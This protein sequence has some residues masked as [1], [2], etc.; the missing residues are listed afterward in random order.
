[1]SSGRPPGCT[2]AQRASAETTLAK[3]LVSDDQESHIGLQVKQEL[4]QKEHVK[5][6]DDAEIVAFVRSITGRILPLAEKDRPGVKW[7]VQ[8]IDDPKTVNAFATP[9]G[10]LYVF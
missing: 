7:Q 4:E 5:Y 2:H 10:Y 9:G 1:M 6:L 8:V 3:A